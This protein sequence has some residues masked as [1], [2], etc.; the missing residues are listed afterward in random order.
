MMFSNV[1]NLE[2]LENKNKWKEAVDLLYNLYNNDKSPSNFIR[3]ASE[4]WYVLS[5][6][7]FLS[8]VS[9]KDENYFKNI[10]SELYKEIQTQFSDNSDVLTIIGYMSSMFPFYFY[11]D[12]TDENFLTYEQQGLKMLKKATEL[13]KNNLF[14]ETLFFGTQNLKKYE[15][16]KEKL[17]KEFDKYI[18]G[19]TAI[20]N[21]FREVIGIS[22]KQSEK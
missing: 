3:L 18:S 10:L 12:N 1:E 2:T 15:K 11:E 21:Y 13:D 14:A 9:E 16:S 17:L 19:N 22:Q 4:C 5:Q 20:E 7:E 6:S 8:G